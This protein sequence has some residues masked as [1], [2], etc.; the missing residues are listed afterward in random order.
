MSGTATAAVAV[1]RTPAMLLAYLTLTQLMK[2]WLIRRF[3]L[4]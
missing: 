1:C 2:T 3:G 4:S